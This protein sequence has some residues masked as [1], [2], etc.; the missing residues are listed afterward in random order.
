VIINES[1]RIV[2]CKKPFGI[3]YAQELYWA[4]G[5]EKKFPET[6]V[7]PIRSKEK[8]WI[9]FDHSLYLIRHQTVVSEFHLDQ[10]DHRIYNAAYSRI[11]RSDIGIF[12]RGPKSPTKADSS[13]N[14]NKRYIFLKQ[15]T[16]EVLAIPEPRPNTLGAMVDETEQQVVVRAGWDVYRYSDGWSHVRLPG[17]AVM[18]LPGKHWVFFD[19]K[20]KQLRSTDGIIDQMD[21][22]IFSSSDGLLSSSGKYI[23][24]FL[25]ALPDWGLFFRD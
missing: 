7:I 13:L 8:E 12:S 10:P 22:H 17:R 4:F 2:Q 19:Q 5:G 11:D 21:L 3:S 23:A 1:S 18:P 15:Q 16:F 14:W 24:F 9:A 25:G 20:N 6:M